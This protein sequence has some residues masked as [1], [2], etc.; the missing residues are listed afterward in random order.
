MMT[1]E[2]GLIRTWRFPRFS[3]FTMLF[4][5][6]RSTLI[7]TILANVATDKIGL[8]LEPLEPWPM[9]THRFSLHAIF[10]WVETFHQK[11][12]HEPHPCASSTAKFKRSTIHGHLGGSYTKHPRKNWPVFPTIFWPRNPFHLFFL[13]V[14]GTVDPNHGGII[15]QMS[16]TLIGPISMRDLGVVRKSG[17]F[18]E[19]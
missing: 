6:S 11:N 14:Q 5:Q 19:I 4:R 7:R 15:Q 10:L 17:N 8:A 9:S 12:T 13:G 16:F 18:L 1:F 3:A 2:F